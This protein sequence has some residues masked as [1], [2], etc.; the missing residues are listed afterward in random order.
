MS[1]PA[2]TEA[3]QFLSLTCRVD[4]VEYLIVNLQ[5]EWRQPDGSAVT[6]TGN[7]YIRDSVEVIG[8]VSTLNV[9]FSPLLTSHAGEYQCMASITIPS[10][11]QSFTNGHITSVFVQSKIY[12]TIMFVLY[13]NYYII[14]IPPPV[15]V[16]SV[17]SGSLVAGGVEDVNITCTATVNYSVV[18]SADLVYSYTWRKRHRQFITNSNRTK[19]KF[20]GNISTLTL[21]PLST[22]DAHFSCTTTVSVSNS[23]DI[24]TS[25][26][27]THYD[28]LDN[29]KG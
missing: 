25:N 11:A 12:L 23:T 24:L 8:R 14:V 19:I 27:S 21:S 4:V 28:L 13:D 3:G 22:R 26:D 2:V 10:V 16:V 17:T 18:D 1:S 15:V 9:S 6:N 20:V 29:I 5:V 7:P